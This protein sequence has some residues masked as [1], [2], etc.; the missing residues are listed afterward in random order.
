MNDLYE[1]D[2]LIIFLKV[3]KTQL[4]P[5]LIPIPISLLLIPKS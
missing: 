5:L 3:Q 4:Q 2:F 1:S